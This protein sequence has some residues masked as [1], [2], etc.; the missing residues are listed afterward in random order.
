MQFART[1]A[2]QNHPAPLGF[3]SKINWLSIRSCDAIQVA[4]ALIKCGLVP[5]PRPTGLAAWLRLLRGRRSVR[6]NR[7]IK[8]EPLALEA[9]IDTA[10]RNPTEILLIGPVRGWVLVLNGSATGAPGDFALLEKLSARFGEAQ[11]F[12]SHRVSDFFAWARAREGVMTRAVVNA[13]G[14]LELGQETDCEKALRKAKDDSDAE[15][16]GEESDGWWPIDEDDVIAVASSWSTDPTQL[17]ELG[18]PEN[19]QAWRLC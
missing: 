14:W 19:P 17:G 2:G 5:A 6:A 18:S 11:C 12:G 1:L 3:G 15:I 9:A 7:P 16:H 13:D 4:D 8:L 10:Y